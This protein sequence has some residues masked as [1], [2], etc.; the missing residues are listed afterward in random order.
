MKLS[1]LKLLTLSLAILISGCSSVQELGHWTSGNEA[2]IKTKK[3]LVIVKAKK[4][5]VRES[6]EKHIT[7]SLKA[8]NLDVTSSYVQYPSL[9]TSDSLSKEQIAEVKAMLIKDGFNGIA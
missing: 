4:P 6:F 1:I 8:E 2:T 7:K 9:I 5:E 3:I